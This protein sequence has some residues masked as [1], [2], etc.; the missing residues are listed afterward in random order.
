MLAHSLIFILLLIIVTI[1][2]VSIVA[3]IVG[4]A[5]RTSIETALLLT[6]TSEFSL[7]IAAAGV[8]S[9][10]ISAELFP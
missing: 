9:G 10:H 6:Q 3:E 1:P 2:L 8:A 4:Y 5:T 7:V